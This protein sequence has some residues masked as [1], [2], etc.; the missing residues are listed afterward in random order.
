MAIPSGSGT[1]VLRNAC[2]HENNAGTALVDWGGTTG[3]GSLRSSQN[4]SGVVAV[5]TNVIIT[6]LCITHMDWIGGAHNAQIDWQGGGTSVALW[7]ETSQPAN[8]TWVWNDK[9]V[10]REGDKLK[11]YNSGTNSDW[12]ISFIYQD[13]S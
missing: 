12:T 8:T 10:L 7:K 11:L 5:P 1:E 4:T 13:W 2:I 9:F 6:V 3:T